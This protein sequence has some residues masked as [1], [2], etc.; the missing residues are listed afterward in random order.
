VTPLHAVRT[1][2]VFAILARV[3]W[4]KV[5]R[6]FIALV[7]DYLTPY[8]YDATLA[9]LSYTITSS[10]Y[11]F[12]VCVSG[13]NDKLGYLVERIMWGVHDLEVQQDRFD[14]ILEKVCN[15]RIYE[16]FRSSH[17]KQAKHDYD[18]FYIDQSGV[19]ADYFSTFSRDPI[20]ILPEDK[21]VELDFVTPQQIIHHKEEL[22]HQTFVTALIHGNIYESVRTHTHAR[23]HPNHV[24]LFPGRTR[25]IPPIE[26]DYQTHSPKPVC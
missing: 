8:L 19:I 13:Y 21:L 14:I 23:T 3:V 5:I 11:G 24:R 6:I 1:R 15:P 26:G 4:L 2:H 9:G 22:L 20:L 25:P 7:N 16:H 10:Y 18:N 17:T 12:S